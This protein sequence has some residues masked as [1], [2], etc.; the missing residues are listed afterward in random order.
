MVN[1]GKWAFIIGVLLA[2]LAGFLT[3]PN[4]ALILLVL[5]LIV[6]FLNITKEEVN[7]YLVAVI[8]LLA[9]GVAGLSAVS[10]LNLT[11]AGWLES[12]M[13]NFIAFV[14]ASG[15]VVALKAIIQLGQSGK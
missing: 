15:L 9:I 13:A 3:I 8:T 6:G 14:G 12:M 4:L 7:D 10:A 2:I 11:V 1:I 5:G